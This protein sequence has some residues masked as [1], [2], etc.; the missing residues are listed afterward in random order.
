MIALKHIQVVLYLFVYPSISSSFACPLHSATSEDQSDRRT[1][2]TPHA[3]RPLTLTL[4]LGPTPAARS[5]TRRRSDNLEERA[6]E[7]TSSARAWRDGVRKKAGQVCGKGRQLQR[8]S[9]WPLP[10][11]WRRTRA[12]RLKWGNRTSSSVSFHQYQ[13]ITL[14]RETE[15]F[16]IVNDKPNAKVI[17]GSIQVTKITSKVRPQTCTDV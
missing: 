8:W 1:A 7:V 12:T 11:A 15:S 13:K 6:A 16:L 4:D 14:P 2:C 17:I 5:R 9:C 3:P 10:S